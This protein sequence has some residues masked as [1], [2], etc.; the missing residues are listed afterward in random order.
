[1]SS[2]TSLSW[3]VSLVSC[4]IF[5]ISACS[6]ETPAAQPMLPVAGEVAK[7]NVSGNTNPWSGRPAA[8][9]GGPAAA[10]AAGSSTLSAGHG[11]GSAG[12]SGNAAA[13]STAGAA[14]LAAG[15][16][17]ASAGSGGAG[18]AAGAAGNPAEDDPFAGLFDPPPLSC[19]GLLCFELGDC[20]T[21]YPD[22][23][24]LCKFTRCEDFVCQ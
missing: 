19:E 3:A 10:G 20:A 21:L 1:M 11:G 12:S 14:A 17:G 2:F 8:N 6:S 23:N 13:G 9:G 4:G 7:T 22:E 15:S 18:G 24:T 16:G 5:S